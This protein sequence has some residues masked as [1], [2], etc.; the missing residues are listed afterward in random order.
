[1]SAMPSDKN[2]PIR[3][4]GSRFV[5]GNITHDAKSVNLQCCT[6]RPSKIRFIL[7]CKTRSLVRK[8]VNSRSRTRNAIFVRLACHLVKELFLFVTQQKTRSSAEKA[9]AKLGV[10][11]SSIWWRALELMSILNP[12]VTPHCAK[13]VLEKLSIVVICFTSWKNDLGQSLLR[14][15]GNWVKLIMS[16]KVMK[17][18]AELNVS[19]VRILQA[20]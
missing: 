7:F 18:A 16:M 1:M 2:E 15:R 20:D 5:G 4:T 17:V 8:W 9:F 10:S 19:T 6:V 12:R 13:S 14:A 11:F 3:I